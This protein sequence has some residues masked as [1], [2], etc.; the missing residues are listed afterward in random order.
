MTCLP[1][2]HAHI[3]SPLTHPMGPLYAGCCSMGFAS[4]CTCTPQALYP[5]SRF[6]DRHCTCP[7]GWRLNILTWSRSWCWDA[8]GWSSCH[9]R[10]GTP[11]WLQQQTVF[12]NTQVPPEAFTK[13]LQQSHTQD[14]MILQRV[15]NDLMRFK[16]TGHTVVIRWRAQPDNHMDCP[17]LHDW[18][19]FYASVCLPPLFFS[20]SPSSAHCF[21][22]WHSPTKNLGSSCFNPHQF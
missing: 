5:I 2:T 6:G 3:L 10:P 18:H 12:S 4:K 9:Q 20:A 14:R 16:K 22:S 13:H 11:V 8:T 7:R 1:S 19:P 15:K 17:I 21:F